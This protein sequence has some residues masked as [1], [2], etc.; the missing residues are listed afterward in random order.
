MGKMIFKFLIEFLLL[1]LSS[2]ATKDIKNRTNIFYIGVFIG[3][4]I[5][6]F[7]LFF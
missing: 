2:F 5:T 6:M 4:I 3:T 1:S 7:D